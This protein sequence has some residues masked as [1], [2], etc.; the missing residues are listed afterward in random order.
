LAAAN[1]DDAALQCA[2]MLLLLLLLR[3][4]DAGR[5]NVHL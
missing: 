4:L 1:V 2:R 3:T 5:L